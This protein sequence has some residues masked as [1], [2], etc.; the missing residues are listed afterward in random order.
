MMLKS[1]TAQLPAQA[2][3]RKAACSQATSFSFALPPVAWA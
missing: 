2:R 3:S 1:L